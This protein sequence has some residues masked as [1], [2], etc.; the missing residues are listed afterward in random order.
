MESQELEPTMRVN[1]PPPVI[2]E[3]RPI[4]FRE[5]T[6]PIANIADSCGIARSSVYTLEKEGSITAKTVKAGHSE[7][8]VFDWADLA[9][10]AKRFNKR[11][12][13]PLK[14]KVK[15]FCN[16]KGGVGKS[17]VAVQFA[18]K[19]SSMG[20]KVLIID[21]DPQA[22]ATLGLG[23][24]YVN[25]K[26]P[27]IAHHWFNDPRIPLESVVQMVT[28]LLGLIPSNITLGSMENLL[29]RE[30]RREYFLQDTITHLRD[31][32]DLIVIDTNPSESV[33]N[34]NA[35]LAADELCIVTATDFLSV[36]GMSHF[37]GV[38]KKLMQIFQIQPAVR[39]IPNL[40]DMRDGIAQ[41][42][43]GALRTMFGKYLTQVV[44]RKNTDIKECQKIEQAIW[45][46]NRKSAGAED[47]E[48]LTDELLNE[49]GV[50]S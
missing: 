10:I 25:T 17:T 46:F 40:F 6:F 43:L 44:I 45:Q 12:E 34:T 21:L 38:L 9:V 3:K 35:I 50:N 11:L 41:E 48:A 23:R 20:Y 22:H 47:I 16:L 13:R 5:M 28:P 1:L 42:S 49:P 31:R 27:T 7:R 14:R 37:F 30:N 15:V 26:K 39:V 29:F 18:M 8:K 24:V 2:D 33:T 19:A 36:D 4:P 32:W